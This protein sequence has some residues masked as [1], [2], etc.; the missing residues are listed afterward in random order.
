ME[1]QQDSSSS[2]RKQLQTWVLEMK[3][4]ILSIVMNNSG[5]LKEVYNS[6][7]DEAIVCTDEQPPEFYQRMLVSCCWSHMHT[8][9]N[10]TV[11][12]CLPCTNLC[13]LVNAGCISVFLHKGSS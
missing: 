3:F 8:Y 9:T 4:L 1:L 10:C 13:C 12:F 2:C 7:M 5:R 6:R 11:A